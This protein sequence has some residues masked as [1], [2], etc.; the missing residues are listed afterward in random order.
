M[1]RTRQILLA[2]L[3]PLPWPH[4]IFRLR[5]DR[6]EQR[7]PDQQLSQQLQDVLSKM[8]R[9]ER[10]FLDLVPHKN[11]LERFIEIR[12]ISSNEC[13]QLVKAESAARPR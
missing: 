2:G 4:R 13:V 10:D 11:V 12:Q 5:A 6:F 9:F 1:S 3:P 8:N 7:V